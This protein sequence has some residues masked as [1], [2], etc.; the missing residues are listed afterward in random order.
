LHVGDARIEP[1]I[2]AVGIEN[3]GHPVVDG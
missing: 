3:H 1:Q 2:V